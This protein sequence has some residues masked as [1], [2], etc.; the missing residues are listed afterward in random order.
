M[1]SISTRVLPGAGICCDARGWRR[2]L[3]WRQLDGFRLNAGIGNDFEGGR[4]EAACPGVRRPFIGNPTASR[5][6]GDRQASSRSARAISGLVYLIPDRRSVRLARAGA[7]A[8]RCA[9]LQDPRRYRSVVAGW[10]RVTMVVIAAWVASARS[11]RWRRS[12]SPPTSRTAATRS[13]RRTS[14]RRPRSCSSDRPTSAVAAS[15]AGGRWSRSRCW[16]KAK[17]PQLVGAPTGKPELFTGAARLLALGLARWEMTATWVGAV[18]KFLRFD[19]RA[20]NG[21]VLEGRA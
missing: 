4:P 3:R 21:S 8:V 12:C 19:R 7:D 18:R 1:Q 16:P 9:G 17:G 20:G 6:A 14:C 2:R 5:S 10:V 13:N 15:A 11:R